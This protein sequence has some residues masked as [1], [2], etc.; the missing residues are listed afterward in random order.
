MDVADYKEGKKRKTKDRFGGF[1]LEEAEEA[2]NCESEND[3]D[4]VI[5]ELDSV[6]NEYVENGPTAR[7]IDDSQRASLL[8]NQNVEYLEE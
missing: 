4:E 7:D 8:G 2:E 3:C 5:E 1:I 6:K